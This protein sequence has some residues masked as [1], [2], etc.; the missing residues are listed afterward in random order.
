M[1]TLKVFLLLLYVLLFTQTNGNGLN[2]QNNI[3]KNPSAE[4]FTKKRKSPLNWGKYVGCGKHYFTSTSDEAH[5]G[6]RS[7][8]LRILSDENNNK[9][10]LGVMG[11]DSNGYEG[12]NA[13]KVEAETTYEFSFWIKGSVPSIEVQCIG[14]KDIAAKYK[15]RQKIPTSIYKIKVSP[16]WKKYEGTF[17]TFKD[18]CKVAL[19]FMIYAKGENCKAYVGKEFYVD[20]LSM[21]EQEQKTNTEK[22]AA[23]KAQI[24]STSSANGET[25][26]LGIIPSP[27]HVHLE[28]GWFFLETNA[29]PA[30]SLI[31][32][33][34]PSVKTLIGAKEII[35][36]VG[37]AKYNASLPPKDRNIILI[38]TPE[39]NK[40]I[41]KYVSPQELPKNQEGYVIRFFKEE[42][43][44]V[45]VL[46][47]KT[48]QG[49]LYACITFCELI[50]KTKKSRY[51]LK[52]NITDYPDFYGRMGVGGKILTKS[53][54]DRAL[55]Y[56]L[57][58]GWGHNTLIPKSNIDEK[59]WFQLNKYAWERGIRIIYKDW[60][61][62]GKVPQK[63]VKNSRYYSV[64]GKIGYYKKLFCWSDDN[65]IKQKCEILNNFIKT[66][67]AKGIYL[68][69]MDTGGV[70]DPE[71]WS[72]RCNSCRKKFGDDRA[73]ADAYLLNNFYKSIIKASKDTQLHV[74]IYPY[75]GSSL[76]YPWI[77]SWLKKLNTLA[78]PKIFFAWRESQLKN[79]KKL[80]ELCPGRRFI[81][82]HEPV[83]CGLSF[84]CPPDFSKAITFYN[85]NTKDIYWYNYT[86]LSALGAAEFS[87]NTKALGASF[88]SKKNLHDSTNKLGDVTVPDVVRKK[89]LPRICKQVFGSDIAK[90]MS[91]V[92]SKNL[93]AKLAITPRSFFNDTEALKFFQYQMDSAASGITVLEKISPHQIKAEGKALFFKEFAKNIAAKY[94]SEAR[95]NI[96]MQ[97]E[98]IAKGKFQKAEENIKRIKEIL[99]LGAVKLK[100]QGLSNQFNYK[101]ARSSMLAEI[102]TID[103]NWI[104][105]KKRYLKGL[106][107]KKISVGI[108]KDGFGIEGLRWG[109]GEV[110]GISLNIFYDLNM[111]T[112]N[113]F[114]VIIFSGTKNVEM[115]DIEDKDWSKR[116][117]KFV[118]NG[119]GV[120]FTHNACGRYITFPS[121]FTEICE[122]VLGRNKNRELHIA[123][124]HPITSDF[125]KNNAF[126]HTSDDHLLLRKGN[127]GSV[128]IKDIK[129]NNIVLVGRVGEGKVVFLGNLP[130]LGKKDQSVELKNEEFKILIRAIRWLATK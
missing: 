5:T 3:I 19:K 81:F 44:D 20:D 63:Q 112:I 113:K 124:L 30:A 43:R 53:D 107:P 68:H 10:H 23:F 67:G 11:G 60:W 58:R 54:V 61:N 59:K 51:T 24:I 55:R 91:Q 52:A 74:A 18:T 111:Q 66:T 77:S 70:S 50:R 39:E 99:A 56:K 28:K 115:G 78:N 125:N 98:Y 100:Q 73:K 15:D 94:L 114:D 31:L 40:L 90:Q 76:K 118:S 65:L 64:N 130:G 126:I 121:M 103:K 120:I 117:R 45:A 101:K 35:K 87:W 85:K 26:S 82:Y 21:I 84:S 69:A 127:K 72:G 12:R 128:L 41:N 86:G 89:L 75:L 80:R 4:S 110:P 96:I 6:K 16:E 37:L 38:G 116:I 97:K 25:N 46:A 9:I 62:V 95:L 47:G 36:K 119:G 102:M 83:P 29:G 2:A 79:I 104:K 122:G 33:K 32:G 108:Y 14:W 49:T 105:E 88:I 7:V 13:Y 8:C 27:K 42:D 48:P 109:L 71:N 129:G 123:S 92:F 57:N 17:T 106:C 34:S 22:D 1:K 93:S